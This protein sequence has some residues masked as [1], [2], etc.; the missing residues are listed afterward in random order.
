MNKVLAILSPLLWLVH[1]FCLNEIDFL[2]KH[3]LDVL[4]R[5]MVS[6]SI[7]Y[8]I[9]YLWTYHDLRDK[10]YYLMVKENDN[11]NNIKH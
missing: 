4:V 2:Y 7:G 11:C 3:Q 5:V 10:I 9:F 6:V 8:S 1:S